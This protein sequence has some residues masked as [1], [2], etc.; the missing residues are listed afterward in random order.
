MAQPW[1]QKKFWIQ[2]MILDTSEAKLENALKNIDG[3]MT[4]KASYMNSNVCFSYNPEKT[5]L[6]SISTIISNLGYIALEKSPEPVIY[7]SRLVPRL[8][9]NSRSRTDP[10]H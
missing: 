4:V 3:V 8:K 5:T 6:K 10:E 2:G 9:T 7:K 1:L